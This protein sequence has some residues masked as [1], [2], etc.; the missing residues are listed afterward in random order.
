MSSKKRFNIGNIIMA[1]MLKIM[2]K[3]MKKG[4]SA[5]PPPLIIIPKKLMPNSNIP[6]SD[7]T[8]DR[9]RLVYRCGVCGQ[10]FSL[11][12]DVTISQLTMS[13]WLDEVKGHECK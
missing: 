10:K 6:P 1:V 9:K 7:L 4:G 8:L 5:K 13:G 11:K 12:S 3:A 2:L